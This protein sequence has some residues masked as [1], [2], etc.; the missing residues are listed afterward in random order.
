MAEPVLNGKKFLVVN[1][2]PDVMDVL[3]SFGW[4]GNAWRSRF[5]A[6]QVQSFPGIARRVFY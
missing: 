1:D 3:K 5:S 4:G 2:K 6:V